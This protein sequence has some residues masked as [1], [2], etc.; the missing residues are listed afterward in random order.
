M[1]SALTHS[2]K[3]VPQELQRNFGP[4]LLLIPIEFLQ[5][6]NLDIE[7]S[8]RKKKKSTFSL[9]CQLCDISF[10]KCVVLS[11]LVFGGRKIILQKPF[12]N[13]WRERRISLRLITTARLA[14]ST[15]RDFFFTRKTFLRR[16]MKNYV[17]FARENLTVRLYK[18]PI[19]MR[20]LLK[21]RQTVTFFTGYDTKTDRYLK[22]FIHS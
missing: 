6:S 20:Y 19:K 8:E 12:V 16:E 3:I 17:F 10:R 21:I 13:G 11:P 18:G 1:S 9:L 4:I 7:K 15:T 5:P 22:L 2:F 14:L